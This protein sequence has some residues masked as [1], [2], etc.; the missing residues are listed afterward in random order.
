MADVFDVFDCSPGGQFAFQ[1]IASLGIHF[2]GF[3]V[4]FARTIAV[5]RDIPVA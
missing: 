1:T 5:L 3:V 4:V 2:F